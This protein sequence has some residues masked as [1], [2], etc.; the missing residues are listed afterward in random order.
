MGENHSLQ[1]ADQWRRFASIMPIIFWL[2]W[3]DENDKIPS[4]IAPLH[5][6]AND[7]VDIDRRLD[8]VY[9][10][11]LLVSTGVRLLTSRAIAMSEVHR[12][13]IQL[14]LY[15]LQS[16]RMRIKMRPNHH[17]AMHYSLFFQLF[18]PVYAWWLFAFERFNGLLE[19]VKLNGHAN[20]VMELTLMR[21][22]LERHRLYELVAY[23]IL[24]HRNPIDEFFQL[25]LLPDTASEKERALLT[26]L[27]ESL[28]TTR[29]TL[30]TQV[31]GFQ[32]GKLLRDP[33]CILL[34]LLML[35]YVRWDYQDSEN[36]QV[37]QSSS[38]TCRTRSVRT[39]A[40]P[41]LKNLAGTLPGQR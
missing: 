17:L 10:L 25:A 18:G 13:Q 14:K 9:Q 21:A 6:A 37:G 33:D 4:A 32:S 36:N 24:R 41:Y 5:H 8:R 35:R 28:G 26:T 29:G 38:S 40:R 34:M 11:C 23:Y 22:W 2:C 16:I 1:K 7:P 31:A 39:S 3:R 27:C 15:C 20:G 19:K 30:E 12:G